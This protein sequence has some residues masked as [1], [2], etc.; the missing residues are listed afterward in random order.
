MRLSYARSV[1]VAQLIEPL[2]CP[3]NPANN[4]WQKAKGSGYPFLLTAIIRQDSSGT[5][6][7]IKILKSRLS[8]IVT[9][10]A[11]MWQLARCRTVGGYRGAWRQEVRT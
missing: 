1:T 10:I 4:S 9:V 5:A 6:G 2:L 11:C 7:I 3:A 8:L